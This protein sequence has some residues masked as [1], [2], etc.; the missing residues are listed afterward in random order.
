[1]EE[2]A[3]V[4]CRQTIPLW[5]RNVDD[6]FTTI[7]TDEIDDFHEYLNKQNA[8]IR[9]T[10]EIEEN[11]KRPFLDSLVSATTTNCERQC[12]ENRRIL[13]DYLTNHPTARLH[14][15]PRL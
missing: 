11:G 9:F 7:H 6:T 14:T 12:T 2:R 5:L 10:N 4:T 3:L 13:T 1:V 8:D 15:K